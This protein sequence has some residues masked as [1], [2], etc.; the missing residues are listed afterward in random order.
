MGKE[1]MTNDKSS[2]IFDNLVSPYGLAAMSCVLFCVACLIPPSIYSHYM[3]E[4]DLMFLDP[5]TILFYMLCVASFVAGVWILGWIFPS[6]SFTTCEYQTRIAPTFFLLGPLS[7]AVVAAIFM[8]LYLVI[9]YPIL[10]IAV[11]AQQGGEAK[12]TIAFDVDGHF[13][14]VPLALIG[15]MWWAYWR[16]FDLDI[17]GRKKQL[18]RFSVAA[19]LLCTVVSSV[20]TLN[21]STLMLGVC[22][23]TVL[24]MLR[25]AMRK[26]LSFAVILR[27]GIAISL[28]IVFIFFSFSFLRGA[29][30][31]DAQFN[32]LFGY[33][34]AS[35]NRL[36]A[37][38]NGSMHYPFGGQG[39]YLSSFATRTRLLPFS[40]ILNPPD[41][42]E[43]WG[44]EFG[45]VS[46]AGLDG[47][48]IWSGTFGYIYSDL[49]WFSCLFLFGY[50]AI[51][52]IVWSWMKSG[53]TLGVVLYPY[54]GFCILF[55]LGGNYLLDSPVEVMS[56]V[57]LL[58]ACYEFAF[59][60]NIGKRQMPEVE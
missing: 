55:W 14:F 10:L 50:G 23:M 20:I 33:T 43:V 18:V 54:F 15:I 60:K 37:V 8:I 51:Y 58:L 5:K 25:R 11:F 1:G 28:G 41:Y 2:R 52:S 29:G 31:W 12:D 57:A 16:H 3:S 19:A 36:A 48:L 45:A 26:Q 34:I 46:Q 17:Q 47:R 30:N 9:N 49:G 39:I 6:P 4:P 24:Y 42:L 32:T 7:L 22:G 27:S 56:A 44:S 40:Y 13:A 53:K 38:L 21:R 59:M 35:Y